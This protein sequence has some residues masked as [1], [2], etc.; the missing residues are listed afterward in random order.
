MMM[1]I[2]RSVTGP[3]TDA[4]PAEHAVAPPT[5]ARRRL[6]GEQLPVGRRR[7]PQADVPDGRAPAD[8]LAAAAAA[9]GPTPAQ[10]R[11]AATSAVRESRPSAV[12]AA[13]PRALPAV[14]PVAGGHDV[15]GPVSQQQPSSATAA[16]PIGG[17]DTAAVGEPVTTGNAPPTRGGEPAREHGIEKRD[18]R[19]FFF[20][21][22]L[23]SPPPIPHHK[24]VGKNTTAKTFSKKNERVISVLT[25]FF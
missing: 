18:T 11:R 2:R 5:A 6:R 24:G 20:F 9:R 21:L 7:V 4:A 15:G 19:L 1:M 10:R 3:R 23:N 22:L 12:S 25:V 13:S 14:A 17:R 16:G 8:G